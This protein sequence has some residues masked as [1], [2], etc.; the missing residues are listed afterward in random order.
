MSLFVLS[1]RKQFS[2]F[3]KCGC[4]RYYF[5]IKKKTRNSILR[6]LGVSVPCGRQLASC[7]AGSFLSEICH[8][9]K[10]L[11]L[12]NASQKNLRFAQMQYPLLPSLAAPE[13]ENSAFKEIVLWLKTDP[14]MSAFWLAPDPRT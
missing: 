13:L 3:Q 14:T 8:F 1:S 2:S 12:L 11:P 5:A 6:R 7:S 4:R 10:I 9:C